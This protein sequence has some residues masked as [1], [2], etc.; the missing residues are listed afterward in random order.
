[1]A[2]TRRKQKQVKWITT[3]ANFQE[4]CD[5]ICGKHCLCTHQHKTSSYH[6]YVCGTAIIKHMDSPKEIVTHTTLD[7][8]SQGVFVV[9]DLIEVSGIKGIETSVVVKTRDW[10]GKIKSALVNGLV[11]PNPS[12]QQSWITLPRCY[13][14]KELPVKR[15][16]LPT[17]DKLQR[18]Y[19]L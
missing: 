12:G 16:E 13:T 1:M 9:E 7:S 5:S 17:L 8:C 6:Q 14:R 10:E 19:Y 18:S 4:H 2:K 3:K 15:Q 11:V